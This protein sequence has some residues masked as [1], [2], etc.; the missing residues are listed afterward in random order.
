MVFACKRYLSLVK[1]CVQ[2]TCPIALSLF[3]IQRWQADSNH[4]MDVGDI[5]NTWIRQMGYPVVN[6]AID[7][8]RKVLT[9]TQ[10]HFLLDPES[11]VTT[12]SDYE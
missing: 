2:T 4:S 12:P 11:N 7:R 10:K 9:L 1:V 3:T 5:M 6:V 8:T